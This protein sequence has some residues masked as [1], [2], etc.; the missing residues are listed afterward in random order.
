MLRL[1]RVWGE[2]R[3]GQIGNGFSHPPIGWDTLQAYCFV[4]G[5]R[6]V[7]DELDV[8]RA[9]DRVWLEEMRDRQEADRLER[10]RQG[11]ASGNKF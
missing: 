5:S 11:A 9:I 6:F 2:I 8:I 3:S 10:E 7:P 4:T 1:W